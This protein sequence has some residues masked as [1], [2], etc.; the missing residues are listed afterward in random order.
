MTVFVK[1]QL[2]KAVGLINI[3]FVSGKFCLAVQYL[4]ARYSDIRESVFEFLQMSA[5]Y[6]YSE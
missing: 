2:A 1:Q 4:T 6:P 5:K 3:Y